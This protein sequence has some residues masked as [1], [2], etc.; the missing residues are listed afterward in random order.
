MAEKS[1]ILKVKRQDDPQH[2]ATWEEFEI[3]YKPNMN[4]TSVLM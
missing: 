2:A 3:P 4:V 1:I